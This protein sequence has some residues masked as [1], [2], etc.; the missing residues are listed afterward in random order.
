MTTEVA[1]VVGNGLK[2]N[3]TSQWYDLKQYKRTERSDFKLYRAK[4]ITASE[5]VQA[6]ST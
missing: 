3:K 4:N 6:I 1:I 5:V 2:I